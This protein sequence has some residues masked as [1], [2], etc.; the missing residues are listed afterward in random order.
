MSPALLVSIIQGVLTYS[1]QLVEQVRLLLA[2][3]DPTPEDWE[4]LRVKVSKSYDQYID[5]A[6]A[7]VPT[8]IPEESAPPT[9]ETPTT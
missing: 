9:P 7:T 4:A 6:K 8:P 2:K 3:G 1:P 5:E